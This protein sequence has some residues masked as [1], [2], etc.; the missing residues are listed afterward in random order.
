MTSLITFLRLY[1]QEPKVSDPPDLETSQLTC[2]SSHTNWH[3]RIL[4]RRKKFW[5]IA[6]ALSLLLLA[7]LATGTDR[8]PVHAQDDGGVFKHRAPRCTIG[9]ASGTYGYQM[10]GQIVGVGPFLVNGIFT[11]FPNGRMDADVQLVVGPNSFP[12]AGTGGT[13]SINQDCTGSGSF[14][15]AALGLTVTYNFI[16]T[17]GGDQIELLNTNPGIVL[18]GVC[19]RI[20]KGGSAPRCNN[21]TVLGSYGGRLEGS[22]P[23]VP[24]IALA[25]RYT[26]SL[27]QNFGGVL[28]GA[29]MV[30]MMGT[31]VPRTIQGNFTVS[32]NCRGAGS[33]TDDA[34]NTINYVMTAVD[35]GDRIFLM[36]TDPGTAVWGSVTRIK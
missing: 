33:Y 16:A 17:D 6:T 36:G 18:H 13:F 5:I 1:K 15:V 30:S 21:A 11:H 14:L 22:L 19:R 12:A 28:N 32:S 10:A 35:N 31:F 23:G 26:H 8:N 9:T 20:A 3:R 7:T 4:M 2:S 34:G 27:D 29:D 25:G 24:A